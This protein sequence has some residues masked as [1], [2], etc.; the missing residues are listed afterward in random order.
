MQ[1]MWTGSATKSIAEMARLIEILQSP[2]FD[3]A[4]LEGF[5]IHKETARL[6]AS[7]D[8]QP[9][10][11]SDEGWQ[12]SDV[13]IEVPDGEKHSDVSTHPL[14]TFSF[15][16]LYHRSITAVIKRAFSEDSARD[17]HYTPFKSIWKPSHPISS[18]EG[19]DT[20][21][22]PIPEQRIYDEIYSSDAMLEEHAKLQ[23]LPPEPGCKLERVVAALM[24]WSDSTHLASFGNASL[25]PLYMFF[26]NQSKWARCKPRMASCHHIA[27]FPKVCCCIHHFFQPSHILIGMYSFHRNFMTSLHKSLVKHQQRTYFLTVGER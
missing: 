2:D 4:H 16:G 10:R 26:G 14:K 19:A 22:L 7:L 17:F 6:D 11:A 24:F 20:D 3:K 18:N 13:T 5:D 15:P 8:F 21:P 23:N 25:W 27:Y 1:W 9:G 12:E